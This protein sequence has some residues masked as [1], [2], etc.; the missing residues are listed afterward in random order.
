MRQGTSGRHGSARGLLSLVAILVVIPSAWAYINGG[1]YHTTRW[2]FE[3]QLR[4]DHWAVSSGDPLPRDYEA[5]KRISS[6]V[7]ADPPDNAELRHHVSQLVG[8]ALQAL[9]Q[10]EADKIPL[11]VK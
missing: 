9:P 5:T 8:R 1:D 11:S 10:K 4:R 7:R 3:Q 2:A 6:K